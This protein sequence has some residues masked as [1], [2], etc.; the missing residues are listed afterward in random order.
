[1]KSPAEPKSSFPLPTPH[2]K[3]ER[4]KKK[5]GKAASLPYFLTA[6]SLRER[7]GGKG[8]KKKKEREGR[9]INLPST[10]DIP[11]STF[12]NPKKKKKGE[13]KRGKRNPSSATRLLPVSLCP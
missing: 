7:G 11:P 3:R 4:G 12:I 6:H 1:M 5:R 9:R 2:K 10:L 8:K 13:R